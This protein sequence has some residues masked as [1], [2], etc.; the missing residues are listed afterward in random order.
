MKI[1]VFLERTNENKIVDAKTIPEIFGKLRIN[2]Q[3][4]IVVKNDEL[5]TEDEPLEDKDKIKLLSVISG[6]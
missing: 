2:P 1:N 5:I 3:T 4:V 6:G